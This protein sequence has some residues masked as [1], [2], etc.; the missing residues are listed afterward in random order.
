MV[1]RE[2]FRK[3]VAQYFADNK[4]AG[5]I[6]P[7][8]PAPARLIASELG[9]FEL[10]GQKAPTPQTFVRNT[11]IASTAGT[12]GLVLPTGLTKE[13]LPV[14]LELDGPD[15]SDRILLSIGMAMEALFGTLP[16]PK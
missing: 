12:P 14:S 13:G 9:E 5:M 4:L 6:F 3:D 11:A 1:G 7:T 16:S 2:K 15:G 10:N 8:T